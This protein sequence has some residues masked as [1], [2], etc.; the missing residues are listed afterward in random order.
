MSEENG[1]TMQQKTYIHAESDTMEAP[2]VVEWKGNVMSS[3]Y[4]D[5]DDQCFL[6]CRPV[7]S[8]SKGT[9]WIHIVEGGGLLARVGA[10]DT[11]FDAAGDMGWFPV[12]PRCARKIP[13]A[14]KRTSVGRV[15]SRGADV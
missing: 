8:E 7:R 14:F 11:Q 13:A 3:H 1:T 6:C 10:D 9:R 4:D 5:C 2:E 15:A 12:G